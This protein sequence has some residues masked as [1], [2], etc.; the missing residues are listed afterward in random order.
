LFYGLGNETCDFVESSLHLGDL[1]QIGVQSH[2]VPD[3]LPVVEEV[4]SD[5]TRTEFPIFHGLAAE[6]GDSDK[7]AVE[8]P[9]EEEHHCSVVFGHVLANVVDSFI[10]LVEEIA[11]NIFTRESLDSFYVTK[12]FIGNRWL[13]SLNF[14]VLLLGELSQT[15]PNWHDEEHGSEECNRNQRIPPIVD[16]QDDKDGNDHEQGLEE[17]SHVGRQAVLHNLSVRCQS[18]KD[19]ADFAVIK[20]TCVLFDDGLEETLTDWDTDF[21][22]AD[23]VQ[24]VPDA[25]EGGTG[26]KYDNPH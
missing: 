14:L 7:C 12:G 25:R 10:A 8:K 11:S 21:L 9:L 16:G 1:L 19:I 3:D 26:T 4:G 20:E 22:T 2:D 18:R 13:L 24:E 6:E 17:H 23:S 5:L 15:R